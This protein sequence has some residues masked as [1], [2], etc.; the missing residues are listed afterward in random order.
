M[1]F[2]KSIARELHKPCHKIGPRRVL[3]RGPRFQRFFDSELPLLPRD[4]EDDEEDGEDESRP[5]PRLLLFD[6]SS[7][8]PPLSRLR[9][10]SLRDLSDW[11]CDLF[12]WLAMDISSA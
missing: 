10:E 12:D 4:E 8:L 1:I 2:L 3:A 9:D 5:D 6:P 11:D 7:R